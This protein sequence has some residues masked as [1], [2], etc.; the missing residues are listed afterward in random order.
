MT[1]SPVRLVDTDDGPPR[2]TESLV[3]SLIARLDVLQLISGADAVGAL[4]TGVVELGRQVAATAEGHRLKRAIESSLVGKNGD[5]LW[6]SLEIDEWLS[7]LPASPV[8]DHLRNDCSLLLSDDLDSVLESKPRPLVAAP[9]RTSSSG[10]IAACFADY[11][12][13]LW[14]IAGEVRT[15]IESIAEPTVVPEPVIARGP[16]QTRGRILR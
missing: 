9:P 3:A 8:L 4:S 2:T 6:K 11:I 5:A 14:Y 1:A 13:G 10:A 16:E 15:L 7:Q 12:V